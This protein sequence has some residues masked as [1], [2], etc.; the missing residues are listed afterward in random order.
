MCMIA[1]NGGGF[2]L[3]NYKQTPYCKPNMDGVHSLV[4]NI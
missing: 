1:I 2:V 4:E 3:E